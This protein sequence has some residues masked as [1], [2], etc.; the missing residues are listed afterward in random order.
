M[1]LAIADFVSAYFFIFPYHAF[2]KVNFVAGFSDM[3]VDFRLRPRVSHDIGCGRRILPG[4]GFARRHIGI[5]VYLR[6]GYVHEH[7]EIELAALTAIFVIRS[8]CHADVA[9]A[10]VLSGMCGAVVKAVE[11]VN[12]FFD[13]KALGGSSES[14]PFV[15]Y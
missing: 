13:V 9:L 10:Q 11:S 1:G 4:K 3:R 15:G 8:V 5:V 7:I 14:N 6:H 12:H 2:I